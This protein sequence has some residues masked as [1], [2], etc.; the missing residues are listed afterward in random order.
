[1]PDGKYRFQLLYKR[2][3]KQNSFDLGSEAMLSFISYPLIGLII[4][5]F[6]A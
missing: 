2:L 3:P 4:S 6:E 5:L 1:M